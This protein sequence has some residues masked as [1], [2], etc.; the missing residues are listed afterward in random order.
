MDEHIYDLVRIS[1]I[2]SIILILCEAG[3]MLA[4]KL[5]ENIFAGTAGAF[6]TGTLLVIT[7]KLWEHISEVSRSRIDYR[8]RNE[9]PGEIKK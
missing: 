1:V 4:G 9:P 6:I 8:A 3:L 2:A 5:S 7:T